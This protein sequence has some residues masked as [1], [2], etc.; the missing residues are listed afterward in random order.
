MQ[1]GT[2]LADGSPD[3]GPRGR[4]P[5]KYRNGYPGLRFASSGLRDVCGRAREATVL[6]DRE[7]LINSSF[8]T[9]RSGDPES[10]CYELMGCWIPASAGMT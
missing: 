3:G 7:I 6:I 8:R 5:G 9:K 2:F 4:N 10:R 1:S